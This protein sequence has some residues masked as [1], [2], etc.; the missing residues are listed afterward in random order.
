M[1]EIRSIL[2]T[3]R[4]TQSIKATSKMMRISKNTVRRYIRLSRKKGLPLYE[5][6]KKSDEELHKVFYSPEVANEHSRQEVFDRKSEYWI[7][8]LSKVGVTRKLLWEEY[9]EEYPEGFSYS[10]FCDRLKRHIK[11]KDL[12]ITMNHPP[13]EKLMLDFAGKRIA[14]FDEQSG[15]QHWAEVLVGVLPHSHYT[16]AIALPDQKTESFLYG[17]NKALEYVG[18]VPKYILSDNLKAYVI[19][20]DRYEPDYNELT[21]QL[22]NH[23]DVH[24]QSTRVRRPKDKGSVE[25]MVSTVYTRLYAPLRNETFYS[26]EQINDAFIKRLEIHNTEAY[27]KRE[28]N[29]KE[30]FEKYERPLLKDLPSDRFELKKKT[31]AKIQNNYHAFLGEEKNYYSVPHQYVNQY[32]EMVYTSRIVEIYLKGKRIAIHNRLGENE[33]YRYSTQESHQPESH[34]IYEELRQ[35]N[36]T[37]FMEQASAVGEYTHWAIDHI[38]TYQ[39][40]KDQS[41][42]SCLGILRLGKS[43]GYERLEKACKKS[44]STGHVNYKMIKNILSKNLEDLPAQDEPVP[45]VIHENIRGAQT[46]Y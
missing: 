36:D 21:V 13:A 3:Y 44:Q 27:Q 26:L 34:R 10:Q 9:R 39:P 22:A 25:N 29:R 31:R 30:V 35:Y 19:R 41:Y 18:G 17:L 23:Y 20:A 4:I 5:I 2:K 1:D 40:N 7:N 45:K 33:R 28:G 24:L 12:T 16:F 42:K 37:D 46:Y 43:Y 14:W 38:L 8:E 6:E 15:E 32:V 11:R